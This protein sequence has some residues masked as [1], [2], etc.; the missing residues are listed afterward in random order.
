[1]DTYRTF[2]DLE[3]KF[4]ARSKVFCSL[5]KKEQDVKCKKILARRNPRQFPTTTIF[6]A[7]FSQ[8]QFPTRQLPTRRFPTISHS[9]ISHSTVS[10][11]QIPTKTVSH[12]TFSQK[13]ISYPTYP[14][15]DS[16][17]LRQFPTTTF[18]HYMIF[19]F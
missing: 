19:S 8:L 3:A 2:T 7:T 13:T 15:R 12:S 10:Q 14:H 5:L 18:S 17:P 1:M 4:F 16:F 6:H 9:T 11:K